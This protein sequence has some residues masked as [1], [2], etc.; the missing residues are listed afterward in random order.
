MTEYK[1]NL[2]RVNSDG[3]NVISGFAAVYNNI[4]CAG[5]VILPGAFA[6][7]IQEH[8]SRPL[9]LYHSHSDIA[10]GHLN[11]RD[12]VGT[13]TVLEDRVVGN[14]YGLWFE[15]PV[16]SAPSSQDVAIKAA[17]GHL[18]ECSIG[19]GVVDAER[20][21]VGG[22]SVRLLKE[23]TLREVSLV[24][25]ACNKEALVMEVKEEPTEETKTET[26]EVKEEANMT[27][28][29]KFT[30]EE[31]KSMQKQLHDLTKS[32]DANARLPREEVKEEVKEEKIVHEYKSE[33][34]YKAEQEVKCLQEGDMFA[35]MIT[36]T[37]LVK[38][39]NLATEYK[40]LRTNVAADGGLVAPTK[41]IE[42]IKEVR[43]QLNKI[44]SRVMRESVTGAINLLDFDFSEGDSAE[45]E[46]GSSTI[47]DIVDA[48]GSS[49]LD[50]Q[51]FGQII[52]I[53]DRLKRRAFIDMTGFLAKRYARKAE[54][55][56]E[57]HIMTGS[58]NKQPIGITQ[59][60]DDV[61]DANQQKGVTGGTIVAKLTATILR[62]LEMILDEE[63]RAGAE[64][65]ASKLCIR[66]LKLVK[67]GA[68]NF[69]WGDSLV[70]G[71]PST[72]MGY[73]IHES[74]S[75][76]SGSAAGDQPLIFC[77]PQEYL[78]VV[79]EDFS[80]EILDNYRPNSQTGLKFHRAYAG[81]PLDKNAFASLEIQA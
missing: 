43:Q 14:T 24:G 39:E 54:N 12:L 73:P 53:S 60:M 48:F 58:G 21:T 23:L 42:K 47:D 41:L 26:P 64:F 67:N 15:S 69:I 2:G 61:N 3:V 20:G 62:G 77:D 65:H 68:G 49:L 50:P 59:F 52:K 29:E 8:K 55:Q 5:D 28:A 19:Y 81:A 72:L 27:E 34:E 45:D 40:A 25:R 33:A 13:I 44:Q 1:A 4:D 22:Q 38:R 9:N 11:A 16:S 80:V 17:E 36:E 74:K 31:F 75:L 46:N 10:I 66:E 6:K 56:L 78:L 51:D 57:A 30:A 35:A 79:E 71:Q 37:N 63:Y 7:A 70:P 76:E 32:A 18:R